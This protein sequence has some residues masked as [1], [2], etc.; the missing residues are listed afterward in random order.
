MPLIIRRKNLAYFPV[1]KIACT[2]IKHMLHE[3]KTGEQFKPLTRPNGKTVF[4][5]R[6]YSSVPFD[7]LPHAELAP[8][9]KITIIRD[10]IARFLSA[11]SNRVVHYREL[12][13]E[14][15]GPKLA[16]AGLQ[17]DPDLTQFIDR[18]EDYIKT[19]QIINHHTLPMTTFLGTDAGYFDRVYDFSE[20]PQLEAD[21]QALTG[22]TVALPRKQTGGPKLRKSD[23]TPAQIDRIRAY[24]AADYAAFGSILKET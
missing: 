11:Y 23:L 18:F 22:T 16:A 1:P 4:I 5:H 8:L 20:L 14:K 13:E 15:C 24:Y 7:E 19:V 3:M 17:P 6:L 10:P 21:M 12:S 2:S 9:H